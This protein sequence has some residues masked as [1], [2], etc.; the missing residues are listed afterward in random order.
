MKILVVEDDSETAHYV[1]RGLNEA[2]HSADLAV[3]GVDGLMQAVSS[4]YD[5]IVLDRML[6]GL[7]GVSLLR[8]LR[9][10]GVQTPV[11][12]LTAMG[13]ID[14]RVEG[15]NAGGDDYLVKPF[16]FSELLARVS[17]LGRRPPT[18]AAP[19]RFTVADLALD[20]LNRQVTR[21]GRRVELQPREFRLLEYLMR[22]AGRAVT[23]TMLLEQV[24]DFHFD[25]RTNIVETHMSRLRGKVDRGFGKELIETIRGVGYILHDTD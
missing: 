9:S 5:V 18:Q 7:D 12:L 6:P 25:P 14:D 1:Q 15:L 16:A 10:A 3:N 2:G 4:A 24:W 13:G 17:A 21:A 22:N 23:R 20:L 19:T 8:T 11:L